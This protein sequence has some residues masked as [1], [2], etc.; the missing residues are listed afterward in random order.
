MTRL[1][2]QSDHRRSTLQNWIEA[3]ALWTDVP[4]RIAKTLDRW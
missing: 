2:L 3:I 1:H 4:G